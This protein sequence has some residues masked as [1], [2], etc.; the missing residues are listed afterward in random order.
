[1]A[2]YKLA[3]LFALLLLPQLSWANIYPLGYKG[4]G[5]NEQGN[6]N[7]TPDCEEKYH[8]FSDDL[9]ATACTQT[10]DCVL[11]VYGRPC[12]EWKAVNTK[13]KSD[14]KYCMDMRSNYFSH[15]CFVAPVIPSADSVACVEKRCVVATPKSPSTEHR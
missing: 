4:P 11:V 1:M 2:K 13:Y 9:L 8:W 12:P 3:L 5:P 10:T 7:L 15:N 14:F 6:T